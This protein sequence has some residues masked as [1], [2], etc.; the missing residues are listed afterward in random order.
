M[1]EEPRLCSNP[2][3]QRAVMEDCWPNFFRGARDQSLTPRD[4]FSRKEAQ[5][6]QIC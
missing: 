4:P 2:T 1:E 3:K 6:A 5:K